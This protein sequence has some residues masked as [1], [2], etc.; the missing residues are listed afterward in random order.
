MAVRSGRTQT[1]TDGTVPDTQ[2]RAGRLRRQAVGWSTGVPHAL[3]VAL[4]TVTELVRADI[5][6]PGASLADIAPGGTES[7][8]AYAEN[9][10]PLLKSLSEHAWYRFAETLRGLLS[11]GEP[12]VLL[13][14]A[15]FA[16]VVVRLNRY[17]PPRVQWCLSVAAAGYCVPAAV[18][19]VPYLALAGGWALP[20]LLTLGAVVIAASTWAGEPRG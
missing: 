13:W 2:R 5:G 7:V 18:A 3:G 15:V 8:P 14:A 1:R 19:G 9:Y 11:F 17:G 4:L 12:R 10:A 6:E 16:A 20:F